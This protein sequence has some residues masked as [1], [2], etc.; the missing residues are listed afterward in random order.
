MKAMN[1]LLRAGSV[2]VLIASFATAW[3]GEEGM[4]GMP[5]IK[6]KKTYTVPSVEAGEELQ[7]QRG[8]GD[9]ESMV[10][11]MNLMMVGGSGYEGMD[12]SQMKMGGMNMPQGEHGA[13]EAHQGHEMATPDK[14]GPA[15]TGGYDIQTKITPTPPKVG[16]NILEITISDNKLH[17]PV[18]GL[19]LKVQVFMTSMD[20]G[21][22]EPKV[23]EISSGKYQVKAIFSMAGPWAVKLVL[24]H[25]EEQVFRFNVNPK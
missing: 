10:S 15:A 5:M 20:M 17:R 11:M 18:P 22:T 4:P 21:T 23:K 7:S 12:M 9:E 24:P 25:G 13:H 8:Y 1:V 6:P 16:P 14:S 19:K 3:A 2:G